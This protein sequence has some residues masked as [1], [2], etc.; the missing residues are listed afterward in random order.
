MNTSPR[1]R[2]VVV[3]LGFIGAGD[4]ISGDAIGGQRVADLDGTHAG[5]LAANPRVELVA[6]SSRDAG[7]RERFTRRTGVKAY[8]DWREALHRERPVIVSVATYTPQHAEVTIEAVRCGARVVYCEKPIAPTLG[9]AEAMAQACR[10]AGALLVVNHN[11]RFDPNQRKLRDLIASGGLGDLTSAS[12]QWGGGR[13]GNIGTH[14]ID[15]LVMLTGRRVE[16]VSGTLDHTGRRD[17]R[18]EQFRDPGGWGV[19]R[20]SGGLMGTLDAPD[21]GKTPARLQIN[22]TLGR[23]TTAGDEVVIERWGSAEPERWPSARNEASSMDRAAAEIVAWLDGGAA[24]PY[25]AGD[26]AHV[27]EAILA[28]HASAARNAAWVELP[29]R[30]S[31]R[32]L[33]LRSG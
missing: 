32:D 22:G 28:L 19:L 8:A 12:L 18:G 7:R 33:V 21:M 20:W 11:R 1:H 30:G 16:A 17:V 24:F 14:F 9:E 31:E 29:L 15:A 5:A 26:A 23:A 10:S 13:L 27:L 2:A 6:G 4:P 3:G 25:D